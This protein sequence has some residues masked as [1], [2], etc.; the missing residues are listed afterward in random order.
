MIKNG[1]NPVYNNPKVNQI[2][3]SEVEKVIKVVNFI[4]KKD[5][6]SDFK[7]VIEMVKCQLTPVEQETNM[8]YTDEQRHK[9]A[10]WYKNHLVI[11]PDISWSKGSYVLNGKTGT[12]YIIDDN[13]LWIGTS[14][15]TKEKKY[16]FNYRVF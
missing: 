8:D 9:D 3:M 15:M 6:R 2:L 14:S 16:K 10:V 7:D 5:K 12:Y 11:P 1:D 13:G 4:S